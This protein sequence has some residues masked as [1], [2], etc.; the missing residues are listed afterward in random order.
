[1]KPAST[2]GAFVAVVSLALLCVSFLP[3]VTVSIEASTASGSID[4]WHSYGS[5]GMVISLAGVA[6]WAVARFKLLPLAPARNWAV[7]AGVMILLGTA[8]VFVRGVV[9]A[10]ENR[11]IDGQTLGNVSLGYGALLMLAFGVAAAVSTAWRP[12]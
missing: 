7:I 6:L 8:L 4:A 11:S 5:C 2:P 3:L 1:V 12:I 10:S 9:Y